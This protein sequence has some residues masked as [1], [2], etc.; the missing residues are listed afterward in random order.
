MKIYLLALVLLLSIGCGGVVGG[1]GDLKVD[2]LLDSFADAY[3]TGDLEVMES[4]IHEDFYVF[5]QYK[6]KAYFLSQVEGAQN[7][8]GG[9]ERFEIVERNTRISGNTATVEAVRISKRTVE[10][11]SWKFKVVFELVKV[12][13]D[14]FITYYKQGSYIDSWI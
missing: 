6:D 13:E 2:A 11:W 12:G 8:A 1:G 7:N 10:E 5:E 3:L 9:I 14:W 4:I